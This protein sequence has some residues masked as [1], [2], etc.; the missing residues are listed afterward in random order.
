MAYNSLSALKTLCEHSGWTISNLQ[1]NKLLYLAHMFH[2]EETPDSDPLV[3]ETFQAWDYGPVLPSVYH[4]AKVF[5]DSPIRNIYKNRVG[6]PENTLAYRLLS[7]AANFNQDVS[8]GQLVA[9]THWKNGAWAKNYIAG[10]RGRNI[11]NEDIIEEI[12]AR[13]A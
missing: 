9:I 10:A 5:G 4:S 3:R 1:A 11:S 13:A 7:D 6:I 12:N 8:P 2:M